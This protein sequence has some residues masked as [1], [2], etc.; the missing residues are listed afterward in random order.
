MNINTE[1]NQNLWD[2]IKAVLR[3][4][5]IALKTYVREKVSDQ[6]PQLLL[7]ETEKKKSKLKPKWEEERKDKSKNQW[8]GKQKNRENQY[9]QNRL[10]KKMN[11]INKPPISEMRKFT[12]LQFL[13]IL[14]D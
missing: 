9:N 7:W 4:K 13:Q 12:S 2:A 8:N 11:K 6:W 10:L 5:C 14:K 3:G 1:H